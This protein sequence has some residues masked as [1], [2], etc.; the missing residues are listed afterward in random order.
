M[1]LLGLSLVWTNMVPASRSTF[2]RR[3][4][5]AGYVVHLWHANTLT[6][7]HGYAPNDSKARVL[8]AYANR[9]WPRK[10]LVVA[11]LRENW[12]GWTDPA[13]PT[14]KWFTKKWRRLIPKEWLPSNV[15]GDDDVMCRNRR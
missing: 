14:P 1:N 6:G 5:P 7:R 10:E 2:Y 12:D 13:T 8:K 11:W 9:Y 4:T 3:D 15:A